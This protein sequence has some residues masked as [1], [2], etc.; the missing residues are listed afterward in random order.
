MLVLLVCS[1]ADGLS[2]DK[3]PPYSPQYEKQVGR[4]AA[5]E[6]ER[7]YERIDPP[8]V[9]ARLQAMADALAL[10]SA[11]KDVK[12]ELH[13]IRERKPGPKP[14]VNAFSLPGG[15]IYITEGLLAEVQSDHEMAAVL[16]HEITHN[17]HYDGLTL[18]SKAS[19]MFKREMIAVLG[20][21]L[22]GG[23][24]NDAWV[25]VMQGMMFYRH[26]VLG[27]YSID[28]ERRADMGAVDCMIGTPWD[29][30]GLLTFMERLAA[31]ERRTSPPDAGIFQTH[32]LSVD[33][34]HYVIETL[35]E[36]GIPINRRNTT[37]WPRPAVAER[38]VN[39]KPAQV[40][41][42]HDQQIFACDSPG[43]DGTDATGR[44][45]QVAEALGGCLAEGAQLFDFVAGEAEGK[46]ALL[47]DGKVVFVVEEADAALVGKAP[48]DVARDGYAAIRAALSHERL[49]RL[50]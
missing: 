6:I 19:K 32:P 27:G 25:N 16:A 41:L 45:A 7:E 12:Y 5:A 37:R 4:Q 22:I 40:V 20:A 8:D 17:A 38:T 50:Y 36:R 2:A 42:W 13:I 44:A 34:V 29:P 31:E 3:K 46:P 10:N 18:A 28:M 26:S 23:I 49:A 1:S 47:C 35:T 14:E 21:I 33:R 24:E 43:P 9:L 48:A 11:R 39:G 30:V 15:L